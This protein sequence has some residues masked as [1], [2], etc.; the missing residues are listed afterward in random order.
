VYS[1]DGGIATLFTLGNTRGRDGA[2]RAA[3]LVVAGASK[4]L[5]KI[6]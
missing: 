5:K 2:A 1:R 3:A 6:L 4:S